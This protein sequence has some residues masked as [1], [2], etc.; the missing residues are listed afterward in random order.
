M[1]TASNGIVGSGFLVLSP[2]VI[3]A[4]LLGHCPLPF[5]QWGAVGKWNMFLYVIVGKVSAWE[6]V[7]FGYIMVIR[8]GA[9]DI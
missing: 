3:K 2:H 1:A 5:R 9:R 4:S 7:L 6:H 8:G